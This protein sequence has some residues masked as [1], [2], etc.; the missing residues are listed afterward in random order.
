MSIIKAGL[1]LFLV[2]FFT[3]QAISQECYWSSVAGGS[4]WD[5]GR[6]IAVDKNGN[7]YVAGN[8]SSYNCYFNTDTIGA[9][10]FLVKY[11]SSGQEEWVLGIGTQTGTNWE[12]SSG[13]SCIVFDTIRE[14]LL[15]CGSFNNFLN[16]SDS[17]IYLPGTNAFLIKTD[18][19]G[20]TI[21][22]RTAAGL[23][24]TKGSSIGYDVDGNIYL[25]G[26]NSEETSFGKITI[27]KGGFFTKYNPDGNVL[28]AK[29][30]VRYLSS[31]SPFTEA[32]PKSIMCTGNN[33][34]VNG[35]LLNDTIIIDN[36]TL[37]FPSDF[38]ASSFLSSFDSEGNLNWIHDLG[39][40]HASPG[41]QICVDNSF[42]IYSTGIFQGNCIFGND[43]LVNPSG[44]GDSFLVKYSNNGNYQWVRQTQT[45]NMAY[46]MGV[47]ASGQSVNVGGYFSG[48]TQFG[49]TSLTTFGNGMFV[50]GY[51]TDGNFIEAR[52]YGHGQ[53]VNMV[54]DQ[55]NNV[56]FT[57]SYTDTLLIGSTPHPSRGGSDF[58][59]AKCSPLYNNVDN[60][61]N[62]STALNIYANPTTGICNIT[63]PEAFKNEPELSLYV[64][65]NAGKL[66][67]KVQIHH[68][69][70]KFRYSISAKSE[71][72][73]PVVLT[74]GHKVYKGKI[75]FA[76]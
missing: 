30:K 1:T 42:N 23:G 58:F 12:N 46:G 55:N 52:N 14:Q 6:S 22:I 7:S 67:E 49:D 72:T 2:S 10:P 65:D 53:I 75:I 36:T 27:P 20:H 9:F 3:I 35:T 47:S 66:L 21:W 31:I 41:W 15:F 33:L 64:Y 32:F 57:G 73:Y 54:N 50:A 25:S 51:T 39:S 13:I 5:G 11:N 34:I 4:D 71:G 69:N 62:L 76:R 17:V 74:N 24:I 40:P 29:N 16:L 8:T 61:Q 48:V 18:N 56:V 26:F 43:T 44:G 45:S 37:I 68:E 63:I 38:I 28:W 59:A 60:H 19:S 70:D